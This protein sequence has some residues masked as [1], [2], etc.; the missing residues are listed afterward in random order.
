MMAAMLCQEV[1][2]NLLFASIEV[3]PA[4]LDLHTSVT[5]P[6]LQN[7]KNILSSLI[8]IQDSNTMLVQ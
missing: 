5:L 3:A 2:D 4:T 6:E 7:Q 8:Q 1:G